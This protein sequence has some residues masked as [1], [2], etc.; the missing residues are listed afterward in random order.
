[1]KTRHFALLALFAAF[2]SLPQ[3][4]AKADSLTVVEL[5]TSQGCSSC[6]P[7]D[8]ILG[9][10]AKK[11][12]ILPLSFNVDYWNYIGWKDPFSSPKK[13]Q[14]QRDYA[15]KLGLRHV[16]T[17]Q[18][19]INGH[20]EEVGSRR[21]QVLGKIERAAERPRVPVSFSGKGDSLTI[22]IEAG[23]F[24]ATEPA[25]VVLVVFDRKKETEIRRGEN[26]GRKLAYYNVVKSFE[27]IG[28]WSGDA[29]DISIDSGLLAADGDGCAVLLQ[30][31]GVGEIIGAAVMSL[32]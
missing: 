2:V 25:D 30:K 24:S 9:E 26:A 16:Y 20:D 31:A 19:V 12:D 32:R 21:S 10:L 17:P 8:E 6:P 14:R 1:M 29:V 28:Q 5:F 27:R 23:T 18:V 15:R 13:T 3:G 22:N 4:N 11:P 7:A